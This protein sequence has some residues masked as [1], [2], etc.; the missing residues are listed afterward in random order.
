MNTMYLTAKE[1][2][3]LWRVHEETVRRQAR[4]GLIPRLPHMHK[5]LIPKSYV[6]NAAEKKKPLQNNKKEPPLV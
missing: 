3:K 2:A 4:A 5:I 1:V 6:E